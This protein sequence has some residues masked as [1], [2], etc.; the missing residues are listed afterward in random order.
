MPSSLVL[1][2]VSGR[3][4]ITAP[5]SSPYVSALS[6]IARGISKTSI[7]STVDVVPV[8]AA[9]ANSSDHDGS[10]SVPASASRSRYPS[11]IVEAYSR[12]LPTAPLHVGGAVHGLPT[13]KPAGIA[14]DDDETVLPVASLMVRSIVI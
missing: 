14:L 2:E 9:T 5:E 7:T 12:T 3:P 10:E 13:L 1:P 4:G 8:G 6:T 11:A